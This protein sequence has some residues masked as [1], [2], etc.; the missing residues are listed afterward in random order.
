MIT[1]SKAFSVSS[2]MEADTLRKF[3]HALDKTKHWTQINNMKKKSWHLLSFGNKCYH[4]ARSIP[5]GWAAY[6][7]V[8]RT[9]LAAYTI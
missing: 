7:L 4:N 2:G 5:F 8:W 9:I 6:K 1:N 3:D